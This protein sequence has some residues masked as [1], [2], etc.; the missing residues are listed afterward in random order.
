MGGDTKTARTTPTTSTLHQVRRTT[1]TNQM[2]TTLKPLR[3][4]PTTA[5]NKKQPPSA[6]VNPTL[7]TTPTTLTQTHQG[8]NK[9]PEPRPAEAG[10]EHIT[11]KPKQLDISRGSLPT[12]AR[13]FNNL[14]DQSSY[15]AT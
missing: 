6:I 12:P 9:P 14:S 7:P 4:T 8:A 5:T 15:S 13:D 2:V 3:N 10:Q 11:P 1:A